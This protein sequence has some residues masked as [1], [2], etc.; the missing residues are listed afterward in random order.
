[1]TKKLSTSTLLSAVVAMPLLTMGAIAHAQDAAP[2]GSVKVQ[3]RFFN[4][5]AVGQSR[6]TLNP[7][8]SFDIAQRSASSQAEAAPAGRED[9]PGV[10]VRAVRPS[11]PPPFRSPF[12]P[13]GRS[14]F[15]P[16]GRP[17]FDRPG[18]PF[19]PPFDPPGPPSTPPGQQ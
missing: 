13:P 14:P 10:L 3:P 17:P 6:L 8:G 4:P 2:G 7:F 15:D 16:P 11:V 18:P 1:M 19:G 9:A 12:Q 5:F